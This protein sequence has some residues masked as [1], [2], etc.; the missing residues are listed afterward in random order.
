MRWCAGS[1]GAATSARSSS[2]PASA[3]VPALVAV[4]RH[5]RRFPA[6]FFFAPALRLR[7]A[8]ESV[9]RGEFSSAA[10]DTQRA[11]EHAQLGGER[12]RARFSAELAALVGR[13]R[14]RPSDRF[15]F[16]ERDPTSQSGDL[17]ADTPAVRRVVPHT[18]HSTILANDAAWQEIE[19]QIQ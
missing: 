16:A 4:D 13:V 14:L 8:E 2:R 19:A 11:F 3:G 7:E 5:P 9:K 17:P 6:V 12:G 1:T 18:I 10:A 15:Y